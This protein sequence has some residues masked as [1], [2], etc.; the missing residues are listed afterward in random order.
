MPM[1]I[2]KGC[3]YVACVGCMYMSVCI[4]ELGLTMREGLYIQIYMRTHCL[5]VYASI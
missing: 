5:Y 1:Y 2:C 3:I 4:S